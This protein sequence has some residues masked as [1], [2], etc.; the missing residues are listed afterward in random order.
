M[1]GSTCVIS[2][3]GTGV[4]D[5]MENTKKLTA[6]KEEEMVQETHGDQTRNKKIKDNETE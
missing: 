6:D 2:D 1:S 5:K 3:H 4:S